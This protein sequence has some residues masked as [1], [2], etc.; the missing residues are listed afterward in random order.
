LEWPTN[1]ADRRRNLITITPAGTGQLRLL[2]GVLAGVQDKLLAPLS[3]AERQQLTGLL[4]RV[5]EHHTK[6]E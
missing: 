4:A 3:P 6:R 2:D 5:L 1:P